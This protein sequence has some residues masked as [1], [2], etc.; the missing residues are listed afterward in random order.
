M[1]ESGEV[2]PLAVWGLRRLEHCPPHFTKIEF[3]CTVTEKEIT[4]W[5]WKNLTG[6]FYV[7]EWYAQSNAAIIEVR[8]MAA[9][10]SGAEASMFA[11]IID[12]INSGNFNDLF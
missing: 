1:L 12:T 2:N 10:E 11:L 6:R 5:I 3:S 8:K 9:F 4:D 7:G